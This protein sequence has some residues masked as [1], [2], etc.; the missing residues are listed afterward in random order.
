MKTRR[1]LFAILAAAIAAPFIPRARVYRIKTRISVGKIFADKS[2]P[3]RIPVDVNIT[4]ERDGKPFVQGD[5]A[6]EI[7]ALIK[8]DIGDRPARVILETIHA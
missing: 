4:V 5:D 7:A 8:A 3:L 2:G 1:S 6:S